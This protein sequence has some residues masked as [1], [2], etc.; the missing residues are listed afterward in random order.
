MSLAI[1]PKVTSEPGSRVCLRRAKTSKWGRDRHAAAAV[2]L[3]TRHL[4]VAV[5]RILLCY[6]LLLERRGPCRL[7]A[8]ERER[9]EPGQAA[10][11][12]PALNS[13]SVQALTSSARQLS[14]PFP[15]RSRLASR[16][17]SKQLLLRSRRAAE[18]FRRV[19]PA[20]GRRSELPAWPH[21]HCFAHDHALTHSWTASTSDML[22]VDKE[23]WWEIR[24]K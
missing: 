3:P 21:L 11:K 1:Q 24:Y 22:R 8:F 15:H 12:L 17:F 10:S 5:L 18:G 19:F 14:T 16:Q 6:V 13:D 20:R 9:A 4:P 7:T 2:T 23:V